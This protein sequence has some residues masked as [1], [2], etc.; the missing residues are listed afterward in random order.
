MTDPQTD[1]EQFVPLLFALIRVKRHLTA[2]PTFIPRN[3]GEQIQ[4]YHSGAD[5][6]LYIYVDKAWKYVALT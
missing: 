4:V 5:Y 1:M 3:F 6:R 2:A